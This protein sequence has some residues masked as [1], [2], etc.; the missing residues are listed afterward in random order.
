MNQINL[1]SVLDYS[2]KCI[3]FIIQ[4]NLFCSILKC[5]MYTSLEHISSASTLV[6]AEVRL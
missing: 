4:I 5:L 3:R 1:S 6:A 2:Y